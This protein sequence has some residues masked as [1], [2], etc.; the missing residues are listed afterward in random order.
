MRRFTPEF[1]PMHV[2]CSLY[3]YAGAGLLLTRH[4]K[5]YDHRMDAVACD[6]PWAR[7]GESI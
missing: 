6:L 1:R 7:L 3:I 5:C 4:S 2:Q